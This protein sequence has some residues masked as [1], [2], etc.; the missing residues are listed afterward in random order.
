MEERSRLQVKQISDARADETA[1][2]KEAK[3]VAAQQVKAQTQLE[4]ELRA[5]AREGSRKGGMQGPRDPPERGAPPADAEASAEDAISTKPLVQFAEDAVTMAAQL[6][7]PRTLPCRP[8]QALSP[9]PPP[10]TPSRR[11]P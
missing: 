4:R 8:L 10:R 7:L 5:P 6:V 11:Y 1:R 2:V 9:T 3:W